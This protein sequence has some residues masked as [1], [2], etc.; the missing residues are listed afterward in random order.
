MRETRLAQAVLVAAALVPL[1]LH[2][3]ALQ[4]PQTRAAVEVALEM[5]LIMQG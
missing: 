3:L 1:V 2:P 5:I 4:E